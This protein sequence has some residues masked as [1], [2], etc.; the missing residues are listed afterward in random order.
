VTDPSPTLTVGLA[1]FGN[2]YAPVRM[3]MGADRRPDPAASMASAPDLIAAGATDIIVTLKAF[4]RDAAA[5]PDVM[6][7]VRKQFD[8]VTG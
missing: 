7:Q 2:T 6:V 3:V 4:T 1:N 8:A 5:G